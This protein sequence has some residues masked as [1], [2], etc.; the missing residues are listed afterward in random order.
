MHIREAIVDQPQHSLSDIFDEAGK[1]KQEVVNTI[2]GAIR[3]IK[4]R[5]PNLPIDDFFV[6]GAAVTYQYSPTSDIDTTLSVPRA[7]DELFKQA[8]DWIGKNIDSKYNF[9][10]RPYQF[11]VSKGTRNQIEAFDAV[12]DIKGQI[13][14]KKP[15]WI[16]RPDFQKTTMDF[17]K[18][19]SDEESKEHKLYKSVEKTIKPSIEELLEMIK[20]SGGVLNSAIQQQIKNVL[21]RYESIKN[22]RWHS[23]DTSSSTSP[24]SRI[25][26]NWG[27]TNIIYKF[28]EREGYINLFKT[29]KNLVKSNYQNFNTL[30]G[31]INSMLQNVVNS[32][33]GFTMRKP[34]LAAS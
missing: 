13:E 21:K 4:T 24:M 17:Q 12:Y 33:I 14:T 31:Q 26:Q 11:K 25:S 23:F 1:L 30:I 19:I 7:D 28:L 15:V 8:D 34:R 27:T 20:N 2:T 22:M 10:Q 18:F 29:L 32:T 9:G 3:E 16:K 5:F 6:V